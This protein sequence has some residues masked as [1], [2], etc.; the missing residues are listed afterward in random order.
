METSKSLRVL[1]FGFGHMNKLMI[2]YVVE[3]GHNLVGVIGRHNLGE[4]PFVVAGIGDSGLSQRNA[5]QN[6]QIVNEAGAEKVIKESRPD[7]CILATRS[8]ISDVES[9]LSLL[10]SHSVNVITIAEEVFYSWNTAPEITARLEKLFNENKVSFTGTG[11]QDIFWGF[12]PASIVGATHH[13][14]RIKGIMQFNVDDYG[15]A[16]CEAHGVGLTVDQFNQSLANS[17]IPSYNWNSNEWLAAMLGWKIIGTTQKLI[18]IL[19]EQDITSKTFNNTLKTGVVT[20]MKSHVI[21]QCENGIVIETEMIGTVY[22]GSMFDLCSWNIEGE[23]NTELVVNR[24]ATVEITCA[25][26][27]NRLFQIVNARQ[28]YVPS[29]ELGLIPWKK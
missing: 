14:N 27:V 5:T 22:H 17:K 20:G 29:F 15:R 23:P 4:D 8:T 12:L 18:P 7:A 9:V 16:L 26:A 3:K 1:L 19:V 6:L 28:G 25:S 21:T 10:G 2:R 11:V 24:P 13:V